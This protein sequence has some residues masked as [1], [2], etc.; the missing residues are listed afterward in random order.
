M[1]AIQQYALSYIQSW[2][3]LYIGND[4]R[5]SAYINKITELERI[6]THHRFMR[7]WYAACSNN[8]LIQCECYIKYKSTPTPYICIYMFVDFIRNDLAS[9]KCARV[10]KFV[11]KYKISTR[12]KSFFFNTFL[13]RTIVYQIVDQPRRTYI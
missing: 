8:P 5:I 13:Q 10:I 7:W 1:Y 3:W 4:I 6:L 2:G 9:R 12:G 11:E